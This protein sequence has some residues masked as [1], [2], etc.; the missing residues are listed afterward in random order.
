MRER[1]YFL[2]VYDRRAGR[3]TDPVRE[4]ALAERERALSDRAA[5]ILAERV[6]PDVEVVL[7]GAESLEDLRRT[8]A[9]YF[10]SAEEIVAD[11]TGPKR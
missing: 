3:I 10:K 5:R 9:R 1:K 7:L 8:H 6:R 4:Y 11:S 2:L